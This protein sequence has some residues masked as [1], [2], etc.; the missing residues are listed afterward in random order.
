MA[1]IEAVVTLN[2]ENGKSQR[3]TFK[4]EELAGLANDEGTYKATFSAI[5]D[6]QWEQVEG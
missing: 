6:W 3:V 2:F 5:S 1:L 4:A